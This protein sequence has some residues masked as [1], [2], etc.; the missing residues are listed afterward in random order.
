MEKTKAETLHFKTAS[1]I[2]LRVIAEQKIEL[3]GKDLQIEILTAENKRLLAELFG[4]SSERH[5]GDEPF[6]EQDQPE[7][8]KESE[9]DKAA[10]SPDVNADA[11]ESVE[12][13]NISYTR[14][15]KGGKSGRKPLPDYLE[16][17]RVEY[18]LP[19]SELIAPEGFMFVK[20]G[21][22]VT[23]TLDVTPAKVHV[24]CHVHFQY[25]CLER[26]EF[27]VK[28]APVPEQVIPKSIASPG[29]LAHALV[30]KYCYHLPYYRQE[31]IWKDLEVNL[32][33]NTLCTWLL[34]CAEV[35]QPLVSVL[36]N[37]ILKDGYV[38]ADETTVSVQTQTHEKKKDKGQEKAATDKPQIHL[39]YMWAYLNP[40]ARLVLFDYQ[41]GRAGLHPW[42]FFKNYKGYVQA[43]A[44]GGYDCIESA[45]IKRLGCMAH[46]RRRFAE[47]LKQHPRH[48]HANAAICQIK[49]IYKIEEEIRVQNREWAAL[50]QP[51]DYDKI[52]Q[53]RQTEAIPLLT[54]FYTWL[55]DL[56]PKAPPQGP[57]GKAITYSLN[58]WSRLVLYA[59]D[60][61][62]N[63]DNNPV[64]NII[65]PFAIGRKNWLFCGNHTGA[66]AAALIYSLIESAKANHLKPF[67][68]LKYL[69]TNIKSATT[70]AALLKL[71]P[72][73][74]KLDLSLD[75]HYKVKPSG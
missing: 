42:K 7:P 9:A 59:E 19:E 54:K 66:S 65:R 24:I 1:D 20:I 35:L 61:R 3:V 44:Y 32:P 52:K 56:Q 28:I 49:A 39:S 33:R 13:E 47:I 36:K 37:E 34:K 68:Y 50:D 21:E 75:S 16:R 14:K 46:A 38:H 72:H 23:E 31:Q 63:I 4:R 29:L 15:K 27:G 6:D 70:D 22:V 45:D 69:L 2:F 5:V 48:A 40:I 60:G 67:E 43:D 53:K 73:H 30:Q 55:L 10:E 8:E 41:E 64:E 25:A 58:N 57:L 17:T 51:I 62:L 12:M 18:I 11:D 74:A 71:L 26:E